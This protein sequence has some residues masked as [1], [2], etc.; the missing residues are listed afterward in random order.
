MLE[1][2]DRSVAL[3][4]RVGSTPV[5]TVRVGACVGGALELTAPIMNEFRERYPEVVLEWREHAVVDPSAGLVDGA[6]DIAIVRLPLS[7]EGIES[8]ALF[9]EP[10]VAIVAITHRLAGRRSVVIGDLLEDPITVSASGDDAFRAFWSLEAYRRGIPPK[11]VTIHS[12]TEEVQVVGTG[13]AI[14]VTAAATTRYGSHPSLRFL[15]VTDAPP[16]T[17]ALAWRTDTVGPLARR[18]RKVAL[19]VRDRETAILHSIEHPAD[20]YPG[21]P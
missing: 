1:S 7:A 17:V 15:P 14:A 13:A 21:H 11:V 6:S 8:V 12:V 5:A 20:L 3:A 19:A 2:F 4:R 16:S 9:N 10:T 18:F